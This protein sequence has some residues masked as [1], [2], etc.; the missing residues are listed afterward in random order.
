MKPNFLEKKEILH[1]FIASLVIGFIFSFREWGPGQ[2]FDVN[3]GLTNLIRYTIISILV[4]L[5]YITTQKLCALRHGAISNFRIW[6]FK[7]YWLSKSSKFKKPLPIGILLPI[8]LSFF[9]NGHIKFAT[10]GTSEITEIRR[11]GK[12]FKHLTGWETAVIHLAGPLTLSFLSIILF[13]LETFSKLIYV[14]YTI[15]IFSMIPLSSLDG[16]KIFFGSPPLY[17]FGLAL[18][19]SSIFLISAINPI[20]TIILATIIAFT[21]LIFFLYRHL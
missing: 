9:S 12:S 6:S 7:Q 8:L 20:L 11:I 3:I 21:L 18:I 15:A 1:L 13:P 19:I 14:S 5:I 2:T 10:V 17:I 16:A 4:L